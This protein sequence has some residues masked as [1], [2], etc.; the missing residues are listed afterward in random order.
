M[1]FPVNFPIETIDLE[2]WINI[3]SWRLMRNKFNKLSQASTTTTMTRTLEFAY[4]TMK[5]ISSAG[6]APV[7][8]L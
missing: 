4:L 2:F 8:L 1:I 7:S 5:N 3:K 6:F